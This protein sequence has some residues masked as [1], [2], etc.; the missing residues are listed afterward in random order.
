MKIFKLFTILGLVYISFFAVHVASADTT[1]IYTANGRTDIVSSVNSVYTPGD[2]INAT[3][4][5]IT[6][7]DPYA[8]HITLTANNNGA[9]SVTV[10]D[11]PIDIY[12][13]IS[14]YVNVGTAGAPNAAVAV[15]M[16]GVVTTVLPMGNSVVVMFGS[17]NAG[18]QTGFI[19]GARPRTIYIAPPYTELVGGGSTM[20]IYYDRFLTQPVYDQPNVMEEAIGII[21]SLSNQ[22]VVGNRYPISC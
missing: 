9:G 15:A 5:S 2:A 6:T 10:V 21:Y 18:N 1:Y 19:C 16:N 14:A 17:W 11:A 12:S 13:N 4:T 8:S 20:V 7:S 3:V 22:G